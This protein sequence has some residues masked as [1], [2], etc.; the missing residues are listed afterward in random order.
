MTGDEIERRL[1]TGYDRPWIGKFQFTYHAV[2]RAL[3]R[4]IRAEWIAEALEC[5]SRPGAQP[6]TV[7]YY[8]PMA[9]VCINPASREIITVGY[10]RINR[11]LNVCSPQHQSA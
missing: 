7:T 8:G 11:P 3:E 5:S 2:R 10:G 9:K 1:K 6:G 4:N